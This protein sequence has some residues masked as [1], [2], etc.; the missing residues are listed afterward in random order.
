MTERA[1]VV[2][3]LHAFA[4]RTAREHGVADQHAREQ[5]RLINGLAKQILGKRA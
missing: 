2:E 4:A 1:H 5:L 3:L